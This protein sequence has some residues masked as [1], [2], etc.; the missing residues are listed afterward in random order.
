MQN[1]VSITRGLKDAIYAIFDSNGN[2][3]V[4]Y[5]GILYNRNIP[6]ERVDVLAKIIK[7][8][9]NYGY[10]SYYTKIYLNNRDMTIKGVVEYVLENAGEEVTYNSVLGKIMYDKRKL[11]SAFGSSVVL[12][13]VY[14][15]MNIDIYINRLEVFT[16]KMVGESKERSKF[17][18]AIDNN[19]IKSEY[20]G[21]FFEDYGRIIAMY[22][23]KRVDSI[24]DTLNKDEDFRGYFNYLMS[25][26]EIKDSKKAEDRMR[27]INLLES[28][29]LE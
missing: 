11:E 24:Q 8:I 5:A 22:S 4:K 26:V 27:L 16:A 3:R 19:L 2:K 29:Y 18:L 6:N 14:T 7:A 12:D 9:N 21:D 23:K 20:D 17:T 1:D 10:I 15:S 28:G 25:N 13:I